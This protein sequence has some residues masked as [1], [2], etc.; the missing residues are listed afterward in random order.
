MNAESSHNGP[1]EARVRN[2]ELWRERV[3]AELVNSIKFRSR[4]GRVI[5]DLVSEDETA[6]RIADA[7]RA[8][9]AGRWSRKERLFAYALAGSALGVFGLNVWMAVAG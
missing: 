2:L 5:E 6:Q 1:I 7:L 8:S 3:N 9:E 4:Y